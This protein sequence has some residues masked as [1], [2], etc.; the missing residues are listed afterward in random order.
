MVADIMKAEIIVAQKNN[1]I[2]PR[3]TSS[4]CMKNLEIAMSSHTS[5]QLQLTVAILH[6]TVAHMLLH[7]CLLQSMSVPIR[8]HFV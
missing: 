2:W 7:V 6:C 8:T 3:M 4:S 1:R 5:R